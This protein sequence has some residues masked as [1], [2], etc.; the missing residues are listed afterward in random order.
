MFVD[1]LSMLGLVGLALFLFLVAVAIT[2]RGNRLSA[3]VVIVWAL[4]AY[5]IFNQW[6][7]YGWLVLAAALVSSGESVGMS[8]PSK[9]EVPRGSGRAG[10]GVTQSA[11]LDDGAQ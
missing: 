5:G 7:P 11:T 6:P 1:L 10:S 9:F 8:V 4:L 3:A 2:S